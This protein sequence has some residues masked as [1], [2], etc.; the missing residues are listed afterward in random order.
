[1]RAFRP[2]LV[3][4]ASGFDASAVDPLGGKSVT[5]SAYRSIAENLVEVA[6]EICDGRIVFSHAGGYSPVYVPYC[7]LAVLEAMSGAETGVLDSYAF[8][9]ENSPAHL[10]KPWQDDVITEAEASARRLGLV[11]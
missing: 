2:Q 11:V 8:S 10:L 6:E 9:F 4:V 7:G 5:A 3:M 1:L